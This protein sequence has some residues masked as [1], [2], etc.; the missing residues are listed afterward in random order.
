M[1]AD[2]RFRDYEYACNPELD[3]F[4]NGT[5]INAAPFNSNF[6]AITTWSTVI[7]NTNIGPAGL[8]PNQLLPT[9]GAQA[10]FG[11]TAVGVGYKFLAN[12]AT[13]VPLTVSG[14]GGQ[15]A[16]ILNVTTTSGGANAFY[17]DNNGITTAAFLV[18]SAGALS[19]PVAFQTGD[20]TVQRSASTGL[21]NV[22]GSTNAGS[23]DY[24]INNANAW[25]FQHEGVGYAAIFGGAY[26]NASDA[27]LKSNVQP[28]VDALTSIGQ[29]K[30]SSFTWLAYDTPGLGFIAQDVQ[31][32][33]PMLVSTDKDGSMGVN[34]DGIIP[35]CVA[36][37]QEMTSKL[38]AAGVAGF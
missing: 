16:H 22:G 32:V 20:L 9:T 34:Y 19:T 13:A 3:T 14:V 33:L 21:I 8:F 4:V 7:D 38:K 2:R 25:S 35:I 31:A 30:P 12:D 28:V 37:I 29:L 15:S 5:T 27:A 36:A 18:C 26:T 17:V 24:N 11:A 10:T 6:G 1:L 23:A